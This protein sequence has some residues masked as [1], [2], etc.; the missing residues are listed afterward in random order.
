MNLPVSKKR[1]RAWA[2]AAAAVALAAGGLVLSSV[3]EP[4]GAVPATSTPTT[5]TPTTP[6][7]TAPTPTPTTPASGT[8]RATLRGPHLDGFLAFTEG[9]ALANGARDLYA[10]LRLTG[11]DQGVARRVPVSLAVVLDHSGSMGG[12]KMVQAREAVVALLA[13]MHDDDRLAVIVYDHEAS[14][15]QPLASVAELRRTLPAR[16]REV[17]AAGG[18]NIPA[19]LDLGAAALASAPAAHVRR[20]V[21]ISD[22][23]DGS[24]EPLPSISARVA[25][26]AGD[27]VTTS[28]L[29]IGVDYDETFLSTVADSGRGNYQFLAEGSM[30]DPFL[31]RELEQAGTTVA[32]D[33]MAELE[34]PP[35]AVLRRAHGAVA[36]IDGARVRLPLG[37]IFAGE[38]RKVV[39]EIAAPIG[40]P[41]SLASTSVRLR[42]QAVAEGSAQSIEGGAA[43][44]RAV[45]T[46]AEVD[47]SR[48]A[49]LHADALAT[50]LDARQIDAMAA[51]RG[52]RRDEALRMTDAHLA[53]LRRMQAVAPSAEY[54]GRIAELEHD[55][56]SFEQRAAD[57]Y[58][59]RAWSLGR[60][61]SRRAAAEAF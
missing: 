23:Q 25:Q 1:Q 15:L 50:A 58:E 26:R 5:P 28:S 51:W 43:S 14:V 39:L 36:A 18:T 24:G 47:A 2:L 52:G 21:L 7:P 30:L 3:P 49:D 4:A 32:D 19:G 54:A 10:E 40:A 59:G 61:A 33:V 38:R 42:Y 46:S 12:D 29:G 44:V 16:V 13:R 34:L 53:E 35:G 55:R 17:Q 20:L 8:S 37:A 6:T 56:E 11:D 48:D 31:T 57:S 41:G 9:A 60:G 27:R 22:G 45:G